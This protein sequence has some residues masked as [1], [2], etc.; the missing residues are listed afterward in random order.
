MVLF[1]AF[2]F[3]STVSG[4]CLSSVVSVVNSLSLLIHFSGGFR[5]GFA[6]SHKLSFIFKP[7]WSSLKQ[8]FQKWSITRGS[9]LTLTSGTSSCFQN[10]DGAS[11][12]FQNCGMD[13]RDA[14][15]LSWIPYPQPGRRPDY[16]LG[17][18][19]TVRDH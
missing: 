17:L 14:Y 5:G 11:S 1:I 6:S 10:C 4:T 16:N 19:D 2:D 7:S 18:N 9:K 12:C 15:S 13:P 3:H 8:T